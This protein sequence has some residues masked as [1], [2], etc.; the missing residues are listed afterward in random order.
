MYNVIMWCV[1]TTIATMEKQQF[2]LHVCHFQQY[3]I[4]FSALLLFNT[5]A[6]KTKQYVSYVL[7]TFI[8]RCQ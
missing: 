4:T 1:R 2:V 8:Y 5:A 6:V 7:L 3:K